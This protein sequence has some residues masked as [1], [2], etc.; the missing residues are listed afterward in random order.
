MNS[1]ISSMNSCCP[2]CLNVEETLKHLCKKVF[3]QN[4]PTSTQTGSEAIAMIANQNR[5]LYH[6]SHQVQSGNSGI[7]ILIRDN[8]GHFRA[9]KCIQLRTDS[10]E[11]AEG[12]AILAAVE[13]AKDLKLSKV[14]FESDAKN[15]IDFINDG[16]GVIEW[17]SRN[18]LKDCKSIIPFFESAVFVFTHRDSNRPA[19]SLAKAARLSNNG[20][21][22]FE[23]PPS[24]IFDALTTDET[25]CVNITA[26]S[27]DNVA[28]DSF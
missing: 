16:K 3:D 19:D 5:V 12:L 25:S 7:G 1:T 26:L 24:F 13:W 23:S 27:S 9:A 10:S 17:T 4:C 21:A 6:V 2:F 8:A 11:Q 14:C 20:S 22:S 15:L 18:I 28:T